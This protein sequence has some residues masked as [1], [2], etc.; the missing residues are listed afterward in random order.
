MESLL[1]SGR[2]RRRRR[3]T[4]RLPGRRSARAGA[5]VV[6]TAVACGP[7]DRTP[8]DLVL[9]GGNVLTV[10][11]DDRI[12][13][14]VAVR[15]GRIVA[16]GT[17]E[18]VEGWIGA[19]TDHIDLAGATVTPGL[20]DA[21]AH[22]ASGGVSRLTVLD[23]SFPEVRSIPDVVER[24]AR[25]VAARGPGAW[26][27]G[28][29]W[30]EG[31][32]DELR[33]IYASDLDAVSP[34]NPV[35]L[36]HTMGHYGVANSVAL[37][38]AGI[39]TATADPPGGTIDRAPDGSPTGVL[40]ESSQGL[41]TRLVPGATPEER[42]EGIRSL[43]AEFNREGMTGLK[44]PGIG[45]E[46]WDAYRTVLE[47]GDLTVRVFALW[48]GGET[49]DDARAVIGRIGPSARPNEDPGDGHLVSGGVKL[50][51][52]GS[53]GARTAWMYRPWNRDRDF[54]DGENSGYPASD[55]E[56]LREMIRAYHDAGIHVSVHA[57][58]D[59]GIDWVVDSYAEALDR[60]PTPGLR[61]GIIHANIPTDHALDEMARLQR[62]FDVAYPESSPA[63]TWWIGDT[64]AGNFGPER[65]LRLNPFRTFEERG[66]LWAAGSDYSVTPFPARYGI[67]AAVARETL[68]GVHGSTPFGTG[69]SV[70]ARVALRAFTIRAA[71]QMFLEDRIGSIEVGK[72]ADLAV[73][74]RDLYTI[75]TDEL[76]D[77]SCLMTVFRGRVVWRE[78]EWSPPPGP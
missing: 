32:L 74:D 24:I 10:D 65:S 37:R 20:L 41:V 64:Y 38:L 21:H 17:D 25:E 45:E 40:K 42:R 67:R 75:P 50:Y 31:K 70:D 60:T 28:R 54:I 29:G 34:E 78:P 48:R 9:T 2:T 22:F 56:V 53:G 8:A 51:V 3:R 58:G 23:L 27:R 19:G 43:A 18:E 30:D 46:T 73:W 77:I 47:D 76:D 1:S 14:A 68:R 5:L 66:I 49:M 61:H 69:E 4:G 36:T 7:S 59:R 33:Y 62:E 13:H 52:D 44:D 6:L 57:I 16:V 63:F 35:W 71:R 11:P 72:E 15:D 39:T 26:V 12:V 55:P